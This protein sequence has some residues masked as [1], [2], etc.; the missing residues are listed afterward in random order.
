[1]VKIG[2]FPASG[3]LGT[4]V[5]NHLTKL[6]SPSE[7]VLVARKPGGLDALA[8]AGATVRQADYEEPATLAGVFEGVDV[9]MLISYASFEI[10]FR[11]EVE[12][13]RVP[14]PEIPLVAADVDG[15]QAHE[16]AIDAARRSGV[17][18]IFYSSLAFAGDLEP[19]SAAHVMG[20]HLRTEQLLAERSGGGFTYTAIREGLYSESFPIYTSWF[21][22]HHPADEVAI[23]H[24]GEGPGVAWAKRDELG[25][26]TARIIVDYA[27]ATDPAGFPYL[28]RVVLLSGPAVLSLRETVEELGR[29]VGKPRH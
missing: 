22:I 27:A 20:A 6:V 15:E 18:H 2:V 4:S 28:N 7:L 3:G 5:I 19:T 9:L 10:Q 1:M 11:V 29:A 24:S 26:A 8:R 25:E 13:S 12:C 23:P 14:S 21:D 17:R 16:V